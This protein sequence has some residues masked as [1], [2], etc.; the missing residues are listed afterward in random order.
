MMLLLSL[1][2]VSGIQAVGVVLVAALLVTPAATARLLTKRLPTMIGVSATLG[3]LVS[4]V[5]LYAS[6]YANVASGGAVVLTATLG[7]I[8]ALVFSPRGILARHFPRIKRTNSPGTS[9]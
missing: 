8:L 7:F 3:V 9:P 2:I 4:V 6:Y 5:G 1:T